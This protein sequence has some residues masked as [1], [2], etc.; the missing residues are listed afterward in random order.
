MAN[1][2][3][4]FFSDEKNIKIIERLR[5]AGVNFKSLVEEKSEDEL[6]FNG[7]TFVVTGKL[8]E[9][10][11]DEIKKLIESLGGKVS[12]SV[13]KKTD[14]LIYGEKA[15]S[16]LE[17]AINLGVTRMTEEEFKKML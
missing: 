17:K 1:S 3:I 8:T 7:K 4:E 13:S 5:E 2:V 9:F 12:S 16:K 14:Y 11:R 15:G 6:I 10:K